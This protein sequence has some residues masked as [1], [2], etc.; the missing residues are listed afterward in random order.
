MTFRQIPTH[1]ITGFLGVGKTTLI[2]QLLAEKPLHERWAVLVN[3]FGDIG[4]DAQLMKPAQAEQAQ[5]IFIQEVAGCC[6]CCAA[7][8]PMTTA[9]NQLLKTARPDRLLIEPTGLGHPKE[10]LAALKA[11]HYRDVLALRAT[12]T[13]V[14]ARNIHNPRYTGHATFCQ[15]IEI[16]DWILAS[17]SDLYG[18]DDIPALRAFVNGFAGGS[19]KPVVP[20]ANGR[21]QGFRH[22][23]WLS[24]AQGVAVDATAVAQAPEPSLFLALTVPTVFPAS[25]FKVATAERD[26]YCS[27]GWLFASDICFDVDKVRKHLAGLSFL[28]VKAILNIG[29]QALVINQIDEQLQWSL[30]PSTQYSRLEVIDD[31]PVDH[32]QLQTTLLACLKS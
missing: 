3:E 4:L 6:M 15:Q 1:I 18:V 8:V 2:R 14:D 25:G 24:A 32:Q 27:V 11:E 7:G 28:R 13:L 12:V 29:E 23:Q 19:D 20:L 31:Q 16:A 26:G 5:Q 22:D 9:L 30:Q 17:K 21:L 10:V